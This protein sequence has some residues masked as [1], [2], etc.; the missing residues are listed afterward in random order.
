MSGLRTFYVKE[1]YNIYG[2]TIVRVCIYYKQKFYK[3]TCPPSLMSFML[4]DIRI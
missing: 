2:C 3:F 1:E 4:D